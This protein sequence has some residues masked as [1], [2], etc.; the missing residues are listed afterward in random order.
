MFAGAQFPQSIVIFKLLH[1]DDALLC[2]K[3]IYLLVTN[4]KRHNRNDIFV[5]SDQ[6]PMLIVL[7][8]ACNRLT[9]VLLNLR[10]VP[11]CL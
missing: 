4:F 10:I 3:L 5:G 2:L 6:K 11:H 9:A 8:G 7:S 1:A